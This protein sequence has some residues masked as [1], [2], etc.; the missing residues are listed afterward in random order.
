VE[1]LRKWFGW[2]RGLAMPTTLP[3]EQAADGVEAVENLSRHYEP[4]RLIVIGNVS[5][6]TTGSSSSGNKDANSQYYW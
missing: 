1:I 4:P 3:A 2:H 5:A 6:L